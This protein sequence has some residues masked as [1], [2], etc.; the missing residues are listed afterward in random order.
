VLQKFWAGGAPGPKHDVNSFK[1][2][3]EAN[4]AGAGI[5]YTLRFAKKKKCYKSS[6]H[7]QPSFVQT[8][9]HS[10][11]PPHHAPLEQCVCLCTRARVRVC[12]LCVY[13]CVCVCVCVCVR[14]RA[15]VCTCMH[16]CV[17]CVCVLCMCVSACVCVRVCDVR[18]CVCTCVGVCMRVCVCACMRVFVC[19]CACV[20]ACACACMCVRVCVFVCVRVCVCV[21]MCV[22]VCVRVC[23]C[24]CVCVHA[25]VCGGF[26][27]KGIPLS[28]FPRLMC[29]YGWPGPWECEGCHACNRKSPFVKPSA[30]R[31]PKRGLVMR[32]SLG[33]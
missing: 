5:R 8:Q 10:P 11:H 1:A 14:V 12:V 33:G 4:E 7:S 18:A 22:C 6:R 9:V 23:V 20:R 21:C 28:P 17:M 26:V 25:C 32:G 13:V 24:V 30:H 29:L 27:I 16:V 3:Q 31:L 2:L 15:S 19:V